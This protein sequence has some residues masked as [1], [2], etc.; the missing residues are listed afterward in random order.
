M[1]LKYDQLGIIFLDVCANKI[2]IQPDIQRCDKESSGHSTRDRTY[3]YIKI[4]FDHFLSCHDKLVKATAFC[5][6]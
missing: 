1:V 4:K 6:L 3:K 5:N 2:I